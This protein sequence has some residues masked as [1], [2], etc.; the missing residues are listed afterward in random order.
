MASLSIN[1]SNSGPL[2][3]GDPSTNMKFVNSASHSSFIL[4]GQLVEAMEKLSKT[5]K[6]FLQEATVWHV[7]LLTL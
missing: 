3:E 1:Q 2:K 7:A 4:I 5:N 6:N